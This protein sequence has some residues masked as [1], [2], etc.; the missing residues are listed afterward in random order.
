MGEKKT[1]KRD[2]LLFEAGFRV[3]WYNDTQCHFTL[4]SEHYRAVV[5]VHS[6]A[7]AL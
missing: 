4:D 7:D 1:K 5:L 2:F 6:H 3:S